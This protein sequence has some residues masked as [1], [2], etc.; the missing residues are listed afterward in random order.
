MRCLFNFSVSYS[1]GGLKRLHAYAKWFNANGGASFIIHPRCEPLI[2][3]FLNNRF[4]VVCQTPAQ[5]LFN[6]CGYLP[7]I[8]RETGRPDLYFSYGIAIP[9]R[10]GRVNWFQLTNLLTLT[11][12]HTD[13]PWGDRMKAAALGW[14]YLRALRHADVIAAESAWSLGLIPV[15]HADKLFL[16]VNG[17]DDELANFHASTGET[18]DNVA[19]ILGTHRYKAL[20]DAYRVFDM[21]RQGK[22]GLKLRIIGSEAVIP[23]TLLS[24]G[25]VVPMGLLPRDGAVACLRRTKYYL[26]TTRI[27][28]SYNAAAEGVFSAN[29][30]YISDI[31]PHRELL[32]SSKYARVP[33]P[34]VSRPLLYVKRDE[35]DTSQLRRWEELIVDMIRKA[36]DVLA[37]Q[38]LA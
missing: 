7:A 23:R 32:A 21:L 19:T 5:R 34:G 18:K 28:G 16:A 10:V 8:V 12:G 37:G 29:E 31:G 17:S 35:L 4:H 15:E 14:R 9:R 6:D 27:E 20:D 30:S 1:G 2:R 24:D 13:L 11:S 36:E 26:S 22:R 38:R 25:D 33:I 3:E